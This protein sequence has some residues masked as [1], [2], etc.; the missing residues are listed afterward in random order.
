MRGLVYKIL[1]VQ[2]W[3]GGWRLGDGRLTTRP[4]LVFHLAARVG[5]IAAN[6]H[7]PGLYFHD[8]MRRTPGCIEQ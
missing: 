6:Q 5:G 2:H 8:N 3:I 7:N 4:H 1:G